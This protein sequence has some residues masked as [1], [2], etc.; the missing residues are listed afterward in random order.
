MDSALKRGRSGRKP[1][2]VWTGST[3]ST[4]SGLC[5]QA[6]WQI[7]ASGGDARSQAYDTRRRRELDF[8]FGKK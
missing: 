6:D 2:A 7:G 8:W 5:T 1:K 4:K 3:N